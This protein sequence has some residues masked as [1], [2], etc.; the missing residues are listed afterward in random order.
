MG[1]LVFGLYFNFKIK[2]LLWMNES[3]IYSQAGKDS[4]S[5]EAKRTLAAVTSE[6]S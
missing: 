3:I 5:R 6:E 4:Q 1:G 2:F